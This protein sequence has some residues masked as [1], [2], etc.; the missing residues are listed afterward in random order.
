ME[1]EQ[2]HLSKITRVNVNKKNERHDRTP[3]KKCKFQAISVIGVTEELRL[4][5]YL[6]F[7]ATFFF[8]VIVGYPSI[9][10]HVVFKTDLAPM[11]YLS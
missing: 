6:Q 9:E 10:Q 7:S 1:K 5:D 4:Q 11:T 2:Q 3:G 8:T